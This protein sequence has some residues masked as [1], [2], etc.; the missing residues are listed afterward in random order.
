MRQIS[1]QYHKRLVDFV[2]CRIITAANRR[3]IQM[4]NAYPDMKSFYDN[5]IDVFTKA[6]T[7]AA[8]NFITISF[9]FADYTRKS[10]ETGLDYYEDTLNS[11]NTEELFNAQSEVIKST[12]DDFL[13]LLAKFEKLCS[14]M[15]RQD[16]TSSDIKAVKK[17]SARK[18]TT[19]ETVNSHHQIP[20][21]D[22]GSG[23]LSDSDEFTAKTSESE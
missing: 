8:K 15:L 18:L 23:N 10:I 4:L 19:K 21:S 9:G 3:G 6:A 17:I 2:C 14:D 7:T 16:A 13:A 20:L 1:S 12:F 5:P 22:T 11:R